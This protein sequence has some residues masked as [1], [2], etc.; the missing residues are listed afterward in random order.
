MNGAQWLVQEL[1]AQDVERIFVLCGNGL[2]PFLDAC[3][4][5]GL[6]LVDVRNEQAAAYMADATARL[7]RRLAVVATSAGPGFG[8]AL[9]GLLNSWW[10]GGPTLLISGDSPSATRGLGHF[11]ELDQVAIT[12]SFCKYAAWVH[13]SAVL[14]AALGNAIAAAT[15]PRPGPVHLCI[16]ADVLSQ[17]IEPPD[18]ALP[19]SAVPE[20][21]QPDPEA[22]RAAAGRLAF[23]RSPVLIAGSGAFYGRAGEALQELA[24]LADLPVFTP[25]WD[26]GC[27][28]DPWPQYV[29]VTSG[30]VNGAYRCLAEADLVLTVGARVDF[31]LGYGRPPILGP[32]ARFIRID[33]DAAEVHRIRAADLPIVAA[34]RAAV[35]ALAEAYQ[36]EGGQRKSPW[37]AHV[38]AAREEFLQE[39]EPRG[40][41]DGLPVPSLRL[42]R[43]LEPFLDEDVTFCLDGGNIGRWAHMLLWKRH[44]EHW[45]TCGISG[46]VGWGLP[47]AAAA[48][49]ARPDHPILLLSGDGSAGFTLA[50]IE[51]ALRFRA[52]YVAVVAV[53]DAWGIEADAR[54][55]DQ[56]HATLLGGIRFDRVAEALGARGLFI[57][58]PAQLAPAIREAL[59]LDTVT[60]IHV[61]T[62]LGGIDYLRRANRQ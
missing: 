50:E 53:D 13:R 29:G 46:V 15:A 25:L 28:N 42:V 35:W 10:D 54:P 18:F 19:P 62:E 47:G 12:R 4:E 16:P 17:A 14:P 11:Q 51:T 22:I 1:Q 59:A 41:R 3:I 6:P 60:V 49:L 52:P 37:L 2:R 43:E 58:D 44:P 20:G 8:N 32:E 27:V 55:P 7:T 33:A 30:E 56:R 21:P 31:R 34:P 24:R 57:E 26:R 45:L 23:A 38:R 39:W 40:R 5:A 9:T 48:R 61:P 36:G